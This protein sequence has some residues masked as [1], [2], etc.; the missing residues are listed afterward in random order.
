MDGWMD[1]RIDEQMDR[2]MDRWREGGRQAGINELRNK[3]G[4]YFTPVTINSKKQPN[5][6][7]TG[8]RVGG[9]ITLGHHHQ[10]KPYGIF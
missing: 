7:Q 9:Y 4:T 5:P 6:P 10:S 2:W 8:V 1:G 3:L